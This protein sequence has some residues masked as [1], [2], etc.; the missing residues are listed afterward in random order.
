MK[1]LDVYFQVM[2]LLMQNF[3]FFMPFCNQNGISVSLYEMAGWD[4]GYHLGYKKASKYEN[5]IRNGKYG[6]W[7]FKIQS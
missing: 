6:T 2:N 3:T 5:E 4:A 1:A 7:A